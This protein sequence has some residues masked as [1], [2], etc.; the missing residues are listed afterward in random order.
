VNFSDAVNICAA[1]Q[2]LLGQVLFPKTIGRAAVLSLAVAAFAP[3]G[4][5]V[6]GR[7]VLICSCLLLLALAI[8]LNKVSFQRTLTL[9]PFVVESRAFSK[10][11]S[12]HLLTI[13]TPP[14]SVPNVGSPSQ[15]FGGILGNPDTKFR[16]PL[17][18]VSKPYFR[19]S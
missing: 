8:W 5:L 6:L 1:Q 18:A 10:D 4:T 2:Y 14:G 19:E 17:V 3:M 9:I 7:P 13:L 15:D 16:R 12:I 11:D